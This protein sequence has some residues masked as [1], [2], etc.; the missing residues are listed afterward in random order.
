MK[1]EN[2]KDVQGV[3]WSFGSVISAAAASAAG[4]ILY[5][6]KYIRHDMEIEKAIDAEIKDYQSEEAGRLSYYVSPNKRGTPLLLIHSIN[7]TSSAFEMQPIFEHFQGQRPVYALDLPGFGF[8]DRSNR[9]YS[10]LMYQNAI[11]SFIKNVIGQATDVIALS[12]S[13]EFAALSA[14]HDPENIRSLAMISPTGFQ[15]PKGGS[16]TEHAQKRGVKN[17]VYSGLAIELWNRP[18]YDL[19]SSRP[20]IQFFL[21]KNFEGLVPERFVDYAYQTSHQPGAQH[22]PTYFI[23]GKLNTPAIRE[24]VYQ[25]LTQPVL[26]LYDRDPATNFEMLP[27]FLHEREN[28]KAVRIYPTKGL[29]H[30]DEPAKTF[31]ALDDFWSEQ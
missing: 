29:P 12:L 26:V 27:I 11:T 4:W 23:S 28:W 19:I 9:V 10:P 21:N 15:P 6:R 31:R 8:S 5:S 25:A 1:K 3:L 16:F 24:T 2:K 17:F 22:A 14:V 13:C 7:A 20:T 18:F 30:W